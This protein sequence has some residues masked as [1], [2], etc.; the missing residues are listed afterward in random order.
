MRFIWSDGSLHLEGFTAPV[1]N[2]LLVDGSLFVLLDPETPST[3]ANT[4][5]VCQNMLRFSGSDE[6][7]F[8]GLPTTTTGDTYTSMRSIGNG[9]MLQADSWSGYRVAIGSNGKIARTEF[10]K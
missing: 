10:L 1:L 8:V 3:T 7:H 5:G 4:S 6:P 2:V 9:R